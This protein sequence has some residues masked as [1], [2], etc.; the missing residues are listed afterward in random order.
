MAGRIENLT[1]RPVLLRLNSG[2]TLHLAPRGTSEEVSDVEVKNNAKF[3]KLI[4]RRIIHQPVEK[5]LSPSIHGFE[6]G[7]K[8]KNKSKKSK[9]GKK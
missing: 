2:R 6:K 7:K 4:E 5:K 1:E 9:K 3:E 8:P